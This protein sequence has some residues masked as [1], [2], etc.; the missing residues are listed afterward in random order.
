M[1]IQITKRNIIITPAPKTSKRNGL[2]VYFQRVFDPTAI[3][4]PIAKINLIA[5]Q[6]KYEIPK[7][8]VYT[9]KGIEF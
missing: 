3:D 9:I 8:F 4:L 2:V 1:R 6:S 7:G 5:G